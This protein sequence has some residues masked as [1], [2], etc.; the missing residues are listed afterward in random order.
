MITEK[1]LR[2]LYALARDYSP[3]GQQRVEDMLVEL[4]ADVYPTALRLCTY[5][6][7]GV[8]G[9]TSG[10]TPTM[11]ITTQI[12]QDFVREYEE[13]GTTSLVTFD[14][15]IQSCHNNGVMAPL[16]ILT[17]STCADQ[18]EEETYCVRLLTELSLA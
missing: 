14:R 18:F 2:T 4:T 17:P 1:Q 7:E 12:M 5:W 8:R 16:F 10:G 11:E 6:H 15:V 9:W 3:R 13:K